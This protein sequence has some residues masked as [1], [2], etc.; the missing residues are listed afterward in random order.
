MANYKKYWTF[1][2]EGRG[3][4]PIDMLRYDRCCPYEQEDVQWMSG[5]NQRSAKMISHM[6]PPTVDRWKSFSWDVDLLKEHKA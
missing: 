3:H 2:V 1:T 4:F 6:G 5:T